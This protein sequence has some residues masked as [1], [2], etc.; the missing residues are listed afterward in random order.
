MFDIA[1]T[2]Q[3]TTGAPFDWR[4]CVPAPVA[5]MTWTDYAQVAP[6]QGVTQLAA[7]A[8]QLDDTLQTA[9]ILSLFTDRRASADDLLPNG[10]TN[11]RGW[12]GDAFMGEQG[13]VWGSRLW[14]CYG[15][16][17]ADDLL[18]RARFAAKEALAW[19]VRDGIAGRVDVSSE[20][21]PSGTGRADRLAVRPVIYQSSNKSPIYDVLWGT[22]I[23]RFA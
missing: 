7:Y 15:G 20:W 22:S 1:T 10:V 2:P 19:L 6:V 14:L 4:L 12:L 21:V 16:K 17:V 11:K 8:V 18:E 5:A 9:I 3:A 13:D 23:R